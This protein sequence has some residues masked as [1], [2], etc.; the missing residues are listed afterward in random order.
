MYFSGG[1]KSLPNFPKVTI[2]TNLQEAN[3]YG[4][5]DR[6]AA[7]AMFEGL[8]AELISNIVGDVWYKIGK[9]RLKFIQPVFIGDSVT[10]YV[11]FNQ[12]VDGKAMFDIWCENQDKVKTIVGQAI[13]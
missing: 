12:V 8:I 6:I 13:V 10:P 5:P 1:D 7:G 9:M 11:S 3:D 4:L 2:H